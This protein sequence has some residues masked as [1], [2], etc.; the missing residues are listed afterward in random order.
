MWVR[1]CECV[2]VLAAFLTLTH[3]GDGDLRLLGVRPVGGG[4]DA[5]VD[6]A[7]LVVVGVQQPQRA[8]PQ[9]HPVG[10]HPDVVLPQRR[11]AAAP[12]LAVV[13][14]DVGG[15]L[16]VGEGPGQEGVVQVGGGVAGDADV[17]P[18]GTADL[19]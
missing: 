16:A 1:A 6:A 14:Q 15:V 7:V 5:G 8:V 3:V 19:R 13:R 12:R 18:L 9:G 4:V 10:V 17:P 11:H 2:C